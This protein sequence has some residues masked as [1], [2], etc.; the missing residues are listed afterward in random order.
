MHFRKTRP[1]LPILDGIMDAVSNGLSISD[2]GRLPKL[3]YFG[4][5]KH[6]Y[7]LVSNFLIPGSNLL[8]FKLGLGKL[9]PPE[10][11]PFGSRY[12]FAEVQFEPQQIPTWYQKI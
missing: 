12:Q 5:S 4:K 3:D 6:G 1:K 2:S 9:V 10:Q 11:M 8:R 7:Y